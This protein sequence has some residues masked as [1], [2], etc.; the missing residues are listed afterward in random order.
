[1][2]QSFTYLTDELKSEFLLLVLLGTLVG[3]QI[4]AGPWTLDSIGW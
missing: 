4:D 1:M 2:K 3:T